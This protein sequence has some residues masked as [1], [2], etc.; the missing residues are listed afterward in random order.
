MQRISLG[1]ASSEEKARFARDVGAD[2]TINREDEKLGER[3]SEITHGRGA[4]R[5]DPAHGT[6]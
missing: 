1:V 5:A 2:H 6:E 4:R 3:V